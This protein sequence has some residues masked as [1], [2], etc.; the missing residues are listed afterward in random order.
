MKKKPPQSGQTLAA[1]NDYD[2]VRP[3]HNA[4]ALKQSSNNYSGGLFGVRWDEF[5]QSQPIARKRMT[6]ETL[7]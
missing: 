5:N 3:D 6:G 4:A 1:A 2:F 7:H